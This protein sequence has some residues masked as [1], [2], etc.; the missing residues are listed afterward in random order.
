[1]NCS[2]QLTPLLSQAGEVTKIRGSDSSVA[3]R[4]PEGPSDTQL[5]EAMQKVLAVGGRTLYFSKLSFIGQGRAG[6]FLCKFI[7]SEQVCTGN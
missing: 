2:Q 4:G 6:K 7:L 3:S 1:M 5:D